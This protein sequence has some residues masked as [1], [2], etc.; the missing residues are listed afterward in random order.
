MNEG[1]REGGVGRGGGDMHAQAGRQ[2]AMTDDNS[3]HISWSSTHNYH[4]LLQ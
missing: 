1:M 2:D 3:H 4:Y